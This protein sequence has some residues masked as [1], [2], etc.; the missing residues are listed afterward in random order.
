MRSSLR[1]TSSYSRALSIAIAAWLASSVKSSLCSF[2]KAFS[3]GL[4]RSKTPMQR[5]L[6][7]HR[8]NELGSDVLDEVYITGIFRHVGDEDRLLVERGPSDE[9]L[10][11]LHVLR[12]GALAVADRQL[13]LELP[14][15]LVQEQ[16][17]ERPVVD[18]ALRETRN[19]GQQLVQIQDRRHFPADLRQRLERRHILMLRLEQSRVFD[20]NGHVRRELPQKSFVLRGERAFGITEKI[21]RTD[22]LALPS[23]RD[24]KLREHVP[25]RS[26]VARLLTDVVDKDRPALQY[27]GT[28]DA[29]AELEPH[30]AGDF[31]GIPD[32]V[33]DA[34]LL[35][36][37][38]EKVDGE[39]AEAREASD[40]LRDLRQQLVKVQHGHDLA[41]E[42]EQR[43]E[44]FCVRGRPGGSRPGRFRIGHGVTGLY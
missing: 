5:S 35:P 17:A 26:L 37:V 7:Q 22:D 1:R 10:A 8:N 12:L 34:Q 40:Q 2:V 30:G 25:E 13:H 14:R 44:Q 43:R 32:G 42:L 18:Q 3:S 21:Q 4:S 9:T 23:H 20:R 28:D 39:R 27:R 19:P 38:V 41:S 6:I 36:L 16:D 29:L 33:G 11:E 24:G 15:V 31:L